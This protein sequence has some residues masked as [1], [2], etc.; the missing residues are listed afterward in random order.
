MAR[1][2]GLILYLLVAALAAAVGRIGR[3]WSE[4][5][6]GLPADAWRG[7]LQAGAIVIPLAVVCA[8]FLARAIM[9][10]A[11]SKA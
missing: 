11:Q 5:A 3:D 8:V 4:P 2:R 9:A 7:F 10:G 6:L 1:S